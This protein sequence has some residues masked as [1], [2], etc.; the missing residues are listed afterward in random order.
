MPLWLESHAAVLL[1]SVPIGLLAPRI[2]VEEEFLRRQLKGYDA[3]T[4]RVRHRLIPFLW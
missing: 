3:Y 4:E 2:L 1:A